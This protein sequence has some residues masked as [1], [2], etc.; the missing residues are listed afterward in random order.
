MFD[1]LIPFH[2]WKKGREVFLI[3]KIHRDGD[4][5]QVHQAVPGAGGESED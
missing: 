1:R 3:V 5:A 4:E 2:L